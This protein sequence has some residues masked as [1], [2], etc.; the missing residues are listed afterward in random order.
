M[1]KSIVT[2]FA[3]AAVTVLAAPAAEVDAA[4]STCFYDDLGT[5]DRASLRCSDDRLFVQYLSG[6]TWV[7]SYLFALRSWLLVILKSQ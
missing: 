7:S 6:S 1:F 2:M 3:L 5:Y 4:T